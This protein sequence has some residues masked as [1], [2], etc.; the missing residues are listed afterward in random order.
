MPSINKS[1]VFLALALSASAFGTSGHDARAHHQ[2]M[3][4]HI[5][6]NPSP[7]MDM[8]A[9]NPLRKRQTTRSNS[10]RCAASAEQASSASVSSASVAS[11]S[12][13]SAA[14]SKSSAAAASSSKAAAAAA[15]S[16]KAAAAAKSSEQAKASSEAAAAKSSS[17]AKQNQA[18]KTSSKSPQ[19][20]P[21]SSKS[22]N[23]GGGL[24]TGGVAT[25]FTQNGVAGAC[26]KVHSD[27][28]IICA[29]DTVT[30]ANGANCG[31]TVAI[32]N[33]KTG[34]TV[35]VLV[36]DECPTCEDAQ[37]I[38]LS[39]G[40]FKALGGTVEEGEFPISWKFT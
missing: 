37:S 20:S 3:A 18:A 31:K 19:P 22:S 28:D 7:A 26:G 5:Q 2:G 21:T 14:A 9:P 4:R 24:T 29:L 27:N 25:F 23:S 30:Y 34:Q 32:T 12:S 40:A 16:S 35:N 39:E 6:R 11:V 1:I 10:A 8:I 13:K 17:E 38:D 33:D 36:A 15:S